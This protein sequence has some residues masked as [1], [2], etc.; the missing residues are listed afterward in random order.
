MSACAD[1]TN[2]ETALQV[3]QNESSALATQN[4]ELIDENRREVA[5]LETKSAEEASAASTRSA[6]ILAE[7]Q[8]A[9]EEAIS[10]AQATSEAI[11]AAA[12]RSSLPDVTY[13][14]RTY[15]VIDELDLNGVVVQWWHNHSGRQLAALQ[16]IVDEFNNTNQFGIIVEP[17][18][19][20]D[21]ETIYEKVLVGFSTGDLPGMVQATQSQMAFYQTNE[22]LINLEP[23]FTHP[24]YGL[25]QVEIDDIFTAFLDSERLP[26]YEN[27]LLGMPQDRSMELLVYNADILESLNYAGP[28]RSLAEFEEMACQGTNRNLGRI[29]F[30]IDPTS[31]ALSAYSFASGYDIFDY[32]NNNFTYNN[33]GAIEFAENFQN[34]INRRRCAVVVEERFADQKAFIEGNTLF[35]QTSSANLPFLTA[36]IDGLEE[37][38]N[39][40]VAPIPF[41]GYEPT[42]MVKGESL[43]IPK[44][45]PEE[46]LAAWIFIRHFISPEQ[47][48]RWVRGSNAFPVR[49]SSAA[50]LESYFQ[51]NPKYRSAFDLLKYGRHELSVTGFDA[52]TDEAAKAYA[53]ILVEGEPP[54]LVLVN[55]NSFANQQLFR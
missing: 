37:P 28:P 45:A 55:L 13:D 43:T 1:T 2:L 25:S 26:Q 42:M 18:N 19:E 38:F 10:G 40:N 15:G 17:T 32:E 4:A 20:G 30:Q 29:G 22:G 44:T 14:T 31:D 9:A 11:A 3:A 16:D 7:A 36:E 6:L 21:L 50:F 52:V 34:L 47:Q 5:A 51:E 48:A 53:E 46:Q 49:V 24:V 39:W 8:G 35:I 12:T 41:V 27:Q 23:Y 33:P 54:D